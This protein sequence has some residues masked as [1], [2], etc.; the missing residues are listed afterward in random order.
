MSFWAFKMAGK[1]DTPEPPTD[2]VEAEA[3]FE[4]AEDDTTSSEIAAMAM[5]DPKAPE[6]PAKSGKKGRKK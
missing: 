2:P 5:N 1:R 6:V 4:D 3:T